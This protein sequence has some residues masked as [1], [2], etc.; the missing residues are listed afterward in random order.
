M[1][2]KMT[3]L[4]GISN[5]LFDDTGNTLFDGKLLGLLH[6]LSPEISWQRLQ[7][8]EEIT[9][10]LTNRYDALYVF[11]ERVTENSFDS[12]VPQTKIIARH[13]VGFDSVDL[14]SATTRGILVTNTPFAVRK[15]VATMAVTL[16]LALAQKL[17]LKTN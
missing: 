10:E 6:R 4:V 7:P 1:L 5:V 11:L 9:P 17:I 2:L 8:T 14:D 12:K 3:Y 15:P 16:V 13:G